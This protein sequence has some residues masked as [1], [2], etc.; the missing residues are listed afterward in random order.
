[1]VSNFIDQTVGEELEAL[2]TEGEL[3]DDGR[4]VLW[5]SDEEHSRLIFQLSF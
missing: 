4:K 2:V 1:M 3:E 5:L